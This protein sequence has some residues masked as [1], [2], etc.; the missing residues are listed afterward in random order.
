MFPICKENYDISV[1]VDAHICSTR[2][3]EKKCWLDERDLVGHFIFH[4]N[5]STGVAILFKNPFE[6]KIHGE[7]KDTNGKMVTSSF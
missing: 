1:L 3:S 6:I 7:I 2:K 5:R 4:Q